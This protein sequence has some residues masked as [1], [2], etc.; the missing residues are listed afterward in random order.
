MSF[1]APAIIILLLFLPGVILRSTFQR[2]TFESHPFQLNSIAEELAYGAI[3]SLALHALFASI[4]ERFFVPVD[5]EVASSLLFG[6]AANNPKFEAAIQ[7][8]AANMPSIAFYFAAIYCG[9][10]VFGRASHIL[11]RWT[12]LDT[13]KALWRFEHPWYYLLDGKIL[14]LKQEW[15]MFPSDKVDFS[16]VAA[17][18]VVGDVPYVY[19][20]VLE[21]YEFDR[22]GNL[23]RLVIHDPKRAALSKVEKAEKCEDTNWDEVFSRLQDTKYM[24]ISMKEVLNLSIDYIDISL[25]SE[26]ESCP[27]WPEA[28]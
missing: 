24:V 19:R 26:A 5:F 27:A 9:A 13:S 1:A 7:N 3:G 22:A 28:S 17:L 10:Y 25:E 20:G 11:V 4:A 12:R 18:I 6:P 23:D 15:G 14:D 2:G 21:R 8:V 16:M